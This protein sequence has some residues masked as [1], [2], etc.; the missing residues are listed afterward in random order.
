MDNVRCL[1]CGVV[2]L[3][4]D[5]V[6][7]VC[8]AELQPAIAH[9]DSDPNTRVYGDVIPPFTGP[10]DGIGPTFHLFKN[11]LWLITK[12]VFVIVAPFEV[13]KALSVGHGEFDWQLTLGLL[14]MQRMCDA[15]VAPALFYALLKVIQTG[16]APGVNESYRWGLS[17]FPKLVLVSLI[18]WVLVTIATLLL[19]IPGIILAVAFALVLP[20][21]VFEKGSVVNALRRS[22]QLT[23]GHRWNIFAACFVISLLAGVIGLA[24]GGALSIFVLNGIEFW[25]L[26]VA[27]AVVAD[28]FAEAVT[29]LT[30][31]IYLGILRTLESGQSVIE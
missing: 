4:T 23:S 20:V 3:V 31:V 26:A 12:I 27:A 25:P 7:K 11:N 22:S 19:V 10:S 28:I 5:E 16:S 29:V 18:Y 15:L 30:L 13:F 17:K 24:V 2:N 14:L 6:C 1:R 8:G 21:A 9:T